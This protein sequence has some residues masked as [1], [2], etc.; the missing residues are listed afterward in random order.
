[1]ILQF[2]FL[3][4]LGRDFSCCLGVDLHSSIEVPYIT[5]IQEYFGSLL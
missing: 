3:E 2:L 5:V 1:M 4:V